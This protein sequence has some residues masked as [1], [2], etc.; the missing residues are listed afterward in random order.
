MTTS[1]TRPN[2]VSRERWVTDAD[3]L[4]ARQRFAEQ[5]PGFVPPVA[6]SVARVDDGK[7]TFGHVNGPTSE[8]RLPAVVLASVCG[9]KI[10]ARTSWD[11]KHVHCLLPDTPRRPRGRPVRCR[12]PLTTCV[13][14]VYTPSP[15]EPGPWRNRQLL[16]ENRPTDLSLKVA[17]PAARGWP[18]DTL[19][20]QRLKRPAGLSRPPQ[21]PKARQATRPAPR[22]TR[23]AR[24]GRGA[25]GGTRAG[26]R[27]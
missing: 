26:R 12:L 19:P 9:Y 25:G 18:L 24:A 22:A 20:R 4:V 3:L 2:P 5:I 10:A 6:Y 7:L 15:S 16:Q 8:H 13:G 14:S 21:P 1:S 11:A 27:P 17:I 23:R